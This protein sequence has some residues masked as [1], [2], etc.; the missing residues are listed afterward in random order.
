MVFSQP[1]FGG[2]RQNAEVNGNKAWSVGGNGPTPQL[3]AAEER[4]LQ[5]WLTPR[6]F[7]KGALAAGNAS[8][9]DSD[10]GSHLIT[11]NALNKYSMTGTI[12]NNNLVTRVETIEANPVLGD[13][14]WS[15]P[16]RVLRRRKPQETGLS[17]PGR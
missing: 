17:K 16:R 15:M 14:R 2:Q 12:D 3:A 8:M 9:K 13:M 10:A 7:V 11:F 1:V 4:Q 6:G 5:I